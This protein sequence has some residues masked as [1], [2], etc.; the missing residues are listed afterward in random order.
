MKTGRVLNR[1]TFADLDV[2]AVLDQRDADPFDSAW[3]TAFAAIEALKQ[4]TPVP[5]NDAIREQAFKSVYQ[6]GP[7][8]DLAAYVSDDFGLLHDALALG[9]N[10]PWLVALLASYLRETLPC[11]D[12]VPLPRSFDDLL[13]PF[14]FD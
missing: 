8:G 10:D 12:L 4:Q 6:H 2:A 13:A 3:T 1:A 14:F 11:G 7:G 5:A 9:G